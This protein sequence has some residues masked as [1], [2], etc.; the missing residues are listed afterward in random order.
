MGLT[1]WALEPLALLTM[2]F[3][4]LVQGPFWR[5]HGAGKR[6]DAMGLTIW[7]LEPLALLTML[8]FDF[9][10]MMSRTILEVPW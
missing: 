7:A 6:E 9:S 10:S 5:S 1:I 4:I 3:L 2:L 8:F